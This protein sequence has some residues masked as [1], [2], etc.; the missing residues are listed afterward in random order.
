MKILM[1]CGVFAKE[2]EQ[3]V[4][5]QAKA[6]VEFSANLFQEKLICGFRETFCDFTVLSAPFVGA[7]PT[8]SRMI[9]FKGFK[10]TPAGYHYVRFNNIWGLRNFS[11]AASLKR[12]VRSFADAPDEQ[13]MILVYCTH[14]PFLE[15]AAY[16]KDRD[17][18]IRICLMVPDLP[19]YMNLR[20]D[21][22]RLYDFAKQYDIKKMHKLMACVDSFVLLTE[23]MKE[24]LPVGDKPCRVVEGIIAQLPEPAKMDAAAERE[25]YIVYTG[26]MDGVFGVKSLVDSMSLL[27]DS[28]YRLVLCGQG[29]SFD[30]ALA[31]SKQ[32]PRIMAL[33]QV[34]PETA[35][36]WQSRAAVLI[37]PRANVGEY[38]KY[39]FPSK[40]IEYLLSGKPV[41]AYMLDGMP[42]CYRDFIYEIES[43]VDAAASIAKALRGAVEDNPQR[44]NAKHRDFLRYAQSRLTAQNIANMMMELCN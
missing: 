37:N 32:D 6:P 4:I 9:N 30:Y 44:K 24:A 39:S 36:Q 34:S 1:L 33:G 15:A 14:T 20:A 12:A 7:F 35:A 26:K 13:K 29:D 3:E 17:P 28:D 38:T 43:D 19:E 11:R 42:D 23:Q 18:R 21:R 22:S 5:R 41:A 31:A 10:E 16:A 2:N 8:T 40:N 25:K 27:D